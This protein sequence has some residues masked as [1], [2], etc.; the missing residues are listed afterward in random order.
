MTA[1]PCIAEHGIDK[2]RNE[3]IRHMTKDGIGARLIELRR[4]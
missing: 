4:G 3:P 2:K 1:L